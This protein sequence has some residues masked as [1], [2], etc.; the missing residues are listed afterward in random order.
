MDIKI[1]WYIQHTRECYEKTQAVQDIA[2]VQLF[3]RLTDLEKGHEKGQVYTQ[4]WQNIVL[5][6]MTTM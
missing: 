6:T 5:V 2:P 4:K 1:T 3:W